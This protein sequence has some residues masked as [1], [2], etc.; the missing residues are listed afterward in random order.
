MSWH[1]DWTILKIESVSTL[2]G[3]V[4]RCS[5]HNI[6]A[7]RIGCRFMI[8][9]HFASGFSSVNILFRTK[10]EFILY[11]REEKKTKAVHDDAIGACVL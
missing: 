9:E 10:S 2:N 8:N 6:V 11:P 5:A 4:G 1:V 3:N 7:I